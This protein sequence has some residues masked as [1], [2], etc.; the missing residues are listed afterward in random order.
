[1]R[2]ETLRFGSITQALPTINERERRGWAVVQIV[3]IGEY[4]LVVTF[5]A[6]LATIRE[7]LEYI[8]GEL[9]AERVSM[10]ELIELA[11]LT[12]YIEEGDVELLEPAGMS[13]FPP[14]SIRD[15]LI[16]FFGRYRAEWDG[17]ETSWGD[18]AL[19]LIERLIEEPE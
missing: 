14:P 1:M 9:R 13:E 18:K 8:R 3:T 6:D 17:G 16:E 5:E 10:G 7:R 15:E 12:E 11:E 2:T 19:E 4:A